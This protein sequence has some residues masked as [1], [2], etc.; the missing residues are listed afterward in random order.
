MLETELYKYVEPP[1][2]FPKTKYEPRD[3]VY[4]ERNG[5]IRR[6]RIR[7]MRLEDTGTHKLTEEDDEGNIISRKLMSG[8]ELYY[9]VVVNEEDKFRDWVKEEDLYRN[10]EDVKIKPKRK[11]LYGFC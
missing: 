7:A 1:V 6:S 2:N 8:I 11:L 4:F 10:K 5:K 9:L 3:F